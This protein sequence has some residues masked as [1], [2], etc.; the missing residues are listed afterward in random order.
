MEYRNLDFDGDRV[1]D[2][3]SEIARKYIEEDVSLFGPEEAYMPSDTSVNPIS[4]GG[5]ADSAP[6]LGDFP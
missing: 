2:L 5:G 3:R 1:P 4:P 6:P